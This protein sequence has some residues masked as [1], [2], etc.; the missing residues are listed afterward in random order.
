MSVIDAVK[1]SRHFF[2][3]DY[4]GESH[5]LILSQSPGTADQ[6]GCG[7]TDLL[8]RKQAAKKLDITENQV[9]GLV[10]DGELQ[11]INVGR[12]TKRPR[13]RFTEADLD[14][15]IERRRK[16]GACLSIN[17]KNPNRI[18]GLTSSS[19]VVGF[20][21]RRNAHLAKKPKNSNR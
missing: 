8:N 15:W 4:F 9:T 1:S 11:Y 2:R 10:S 21:A 3:E 12:G 14:E 19:T 17:R 7:M 18:I 16:W 13:M 5:C 20:M 6:E